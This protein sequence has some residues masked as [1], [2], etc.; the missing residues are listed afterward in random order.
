MSN[1]KISIVPLGAVVP[2][3]FRYFESF[4]NNCIVITT[5]PKNSIYG[6][7]FYENSPA[8]FLDNWSE[9]N[10]N[11]IHNLLKIEKLNE[12]DILNLNYFNKNISTEGV[13]NY[14]LKKIKL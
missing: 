6:N 3:S 4:E 14:I 5:Y 11:L 12:F 9:L 2:E 7:W 10:D 1:S 13:S 8:I